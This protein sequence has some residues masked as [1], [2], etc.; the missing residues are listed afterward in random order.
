MLLG[1]ALAA[2]EVKK[3]SLLMKPVQMQM[4]CRQHTRNATCI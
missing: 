3:F 4:I 2:P 1:D